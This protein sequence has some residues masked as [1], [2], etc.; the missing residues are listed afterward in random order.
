MEIRISPSILSADFC[1]LERDLQLISSADMV[2]VDVM[3]GHFVPNITFGLPVVKRICE[4]SPVPLDVHLM[5]ENPDY[6]ALQY[7]DLG[8]YS[9]TFHFEAA[10]DPIATARNIR[11]NKSK[12]GLAVS[13]DTDIGE[14][15]HVLP[16]VDMLQVMTVYPGFGGQKLIRRVLDKFSRITRSEFENLSFSVDGGVTLG[17]ISEIASV[18]VDTFVAGSSV[19]LSQLP[20]DSVESLRKLAKV[21]YKRF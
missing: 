2:H 8:V 15:V 12:V 14:C 1:N 19:F 18:G 9:V 4:V 3:D 16:E 17:N 10:K 13:P 5:V 6:W 7:A 21:A 20:A 11:S